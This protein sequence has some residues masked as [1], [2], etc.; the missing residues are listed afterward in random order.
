LPLCM[1]A[2]AHACI[3]DISTIGT[4]SVVLYVRVA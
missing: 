3:A 1:F 4:S 2:S